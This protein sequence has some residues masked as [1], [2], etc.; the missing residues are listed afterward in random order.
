MYCII[1]LKCPLTDV[2]WV[3]CPTMSSVEAQMNGERKLSRVVYLWKCM[4]LVKLTRVGDFGLIRDLDH[5]H[6]GKEW[7]YHATI[8]VWV[9]VLG[10]QRWQTL[11]WRFESENRNPAE[12]GGAERLSG[13]EGGEY[14]KS[15][16]WRSKRREVVGDSGSSFG[17][18][19]AS[20]NSSFGV[21]D[22]VLVRL[23]GGAEPSV[24]RFLHERCRVPGR[25]S[26][27]LL[28]GF[29]SYSQSLDRLM[30]LLHM[31]LVESQRIFRERLKL[32]SIT[33]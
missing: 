6:G 33:L 22:V 9:P 24:G 31:G 5:T 29:S 13:C 27:P 1:I 26:G 19:D 17:F 4:N 11:W 28:R 8:W 21:S 30:Q 2:I 18:I 3:F 16:G 7:I 14:W 15:G 10:A 20:S 32:G 23:G 25:L 12:E